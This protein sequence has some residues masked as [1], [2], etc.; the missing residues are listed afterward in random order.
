MRLPPGFAII[1]AEQSHAALI[2]DN[3]CRCL[4]EADGTQLPAD[5]ALRGVTRALA[6]GDCAYFL[7]LGPDGEAVGQYKQTHGW[8]DL[9]ARPIIWMEHLYVAR[10]HQERKRG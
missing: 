1:R 7:L 3:N 2:A 10:D 5:V 9:F 6:R 4:Y 8:N